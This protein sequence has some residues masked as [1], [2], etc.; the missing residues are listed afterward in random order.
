MQLSI[1]PL[2][3]YFW[4]SWL[5]NG[6]GLGMLS[7]RRSTEDAPAWWSK[8][9]CVTQSVPGHVC[10]YTAFSPHNAS[11]VNNSITVLL[12]RMRADVS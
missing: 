12:F 9:L 2:A 6:S 8:L 7:G 11:V 10:G 3:V 4:A 1:G 5:G